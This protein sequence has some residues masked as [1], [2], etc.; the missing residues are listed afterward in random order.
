[1]NSYGQ[2]LEDLIWQEDHLL[3]EQKTAN[4]DTVTTF[5]FSDERGIFIGDVQMLKWLV[6]YHSEDYWKAKVKEGASHEDL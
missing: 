3:E 4:L 5:T 6:E 2:I 1:M